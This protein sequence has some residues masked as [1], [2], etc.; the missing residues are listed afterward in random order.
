MHIVGQCV[1]ALQIGAGKEQRTLLE[2]SSVFTHATETRRGGEGTGQRQCGT[3]RLLSGYTP[4]T[5]G[6]SHYLTHTHKHAQ[7]HTKAL[8]LLLLKHPN[9]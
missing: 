9:V 1:S 5:E 7:T 2:K 3:K 6:E 8:P 4:L